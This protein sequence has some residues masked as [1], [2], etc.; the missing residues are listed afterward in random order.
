MVTVVP[1]IRDTVAEE[2][3]WLPHIPVVAAGVN[4]PKTFDVG[5]G[6]RRYR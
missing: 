6:I 4:R 2:T 1:S 5:E 3:A